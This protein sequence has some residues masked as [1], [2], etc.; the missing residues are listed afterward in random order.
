[1]HLEAMED[2]LPG[3]KEVNADYK[4]QIMSVVYDETILKIDLILQAVTD[5]GYVA[6]PTTVD[7]NNRN[8]GSIWKRLFR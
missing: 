4:K 6:I 1:M 2:S 5:M 3:V 8:E 7:D